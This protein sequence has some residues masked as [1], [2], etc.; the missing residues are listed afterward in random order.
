MT[1]LAPPEEHRIPR[2]DNDIVRFSLP[3]LVAVFGL[4][5]G[6]LTGAGTVTGGVWAVAQLVGRL[7]TLSGQLAELT[8]RI[9]KQDKAW[10][11]FWEDRWPA[12]SSTI[13]RVGDNAMSIKRL[14]DRMGTLETVA[15]TGERAHD[16][17]ERRVGRL[18]NRSK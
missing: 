5:A 3:K 9:D 10:S 6:L 15:G 18:E 7:D 13:G 1:N 2:R 11:A 8:N 12:I 17:L 4:C 16:D 14:E